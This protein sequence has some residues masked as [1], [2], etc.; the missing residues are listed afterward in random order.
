MTQNNKAGATK[1]DSNTDSIKEGGLPQDK[2]TAD[3]GDNRRNGDLDGNRTAPK[4]K[5]R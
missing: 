3:A 1:R 5:K 4:E 2:K